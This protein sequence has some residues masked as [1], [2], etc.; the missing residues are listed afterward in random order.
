[1][2]GLPGCGKREGCGGAGWSEL[3]LPLGVGCEEEGVGGSEEVQRALQKPLAELLQRL[4]L[5][6]ETIRRHGSHRR[7]SSARLET[8]SLW[9]HLPVTSG[10]VEMKQILP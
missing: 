7:R 5:H 6:G 8:P 1:V 10:F 2:L 4:R 3:G 9:S